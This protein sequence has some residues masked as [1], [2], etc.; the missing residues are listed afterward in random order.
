MKPRKLKILTKAR[1]DLRRA[2]Q[3]VRRN[4]GNERARQLIARIEAFVRRLA[5]FADIG[6]RH[7]HRRS[8]LRSVGV[9]GLKTITIVFGVS[10]DSVVVYRI[11][12]LGQNVFSEFP[13]LDTEDPIDVTGSAAKRRD[14]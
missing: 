8:G 5:E 9:P 11:G 1:T 6:T 14:R 3:L 7:D 10:D 12:Y 4:D 13:I 2:A